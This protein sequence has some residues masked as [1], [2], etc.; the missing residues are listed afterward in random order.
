VG[1]SVPDT[2]GSEWGPVVEHCDHSREPSGSMKGLTLRS[3]FLP[4]MCNVG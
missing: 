1:E 2:S 3:A 4:S